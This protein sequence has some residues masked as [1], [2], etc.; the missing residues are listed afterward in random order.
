MKPSDAYAQIAMH[1]TDGPDAAK[2][3]Y[4][5]CVKTLECY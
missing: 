4:A 1:K 2:H 5:D 3:Y